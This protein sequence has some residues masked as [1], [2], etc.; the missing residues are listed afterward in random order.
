MRDFSIFLQQLTR[1][2]RAAEVQMLVVDEQQEDAARRRRSSAC[3]AGR[4]TPSCSGDRRRRLLVVGPAAMAQHE[5]DDVL[6]HTVFV[7][8]EVLRFEIGN[9]LSLR[10]ANNDVERDQVGVQ[11]ERRRLQGL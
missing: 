4:K 10:I 1:L 11:P 7:E 6:L 9:E 5:G 8:L 2:R 3:C